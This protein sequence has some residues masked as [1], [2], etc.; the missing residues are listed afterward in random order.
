MYDDD[1]IDVSIIMAIT[2]T[3][4]VMRRLNYYDDDLDVVMII[5]MIMFMMI[6]FV[7][8]SCLYRLS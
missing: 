8:M 2:A 1:D 6:T 5:I 3:I 4:G 7:F